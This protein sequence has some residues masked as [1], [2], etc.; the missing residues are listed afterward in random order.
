MN[1]L[2]RKLVLLIVLLLSSLL[3]VA[4][5]FTNEQ[6]KY[7]Y[8]RDRLQYFVSPGTGFGESVLFSSRNPFEKNVWQGPISTINVTQP[9]MMMGFYLG[10]L[11]T[12]YRLL[13]NN[14]QYDAANKTLLELA[15]ALD[16]LRRMDRCEDLF[17]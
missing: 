10:V 17:I 15:L 14:G 3:I 13:M 4:Q 7:W 5:S 11:A 1:S 2:I 16:V 12:E 8:Y 9:H 6:M